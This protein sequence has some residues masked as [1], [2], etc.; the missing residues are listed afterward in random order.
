[1]SSYE[2]VAG[3][4]KSESNS[5]LVAYVAD[6][7][8]EKQNIWEQRRVVLEAL[9]NQMRFLLSVYNPT[10]NLPNTTKSKKLYYK[11]MLAHQANNV[12]MG[13]KLTPD[14][15]D[16]APLGIE[17]DKQLVNIT[18]ALTR[19]H[20]GLRYQGY[21]DKAVADSKKDLIWGNSFIEMVLKF[22]GDKI[23][24]VEYQHAP[25]A[26]IRNNYGQPDRI[27]AINYTPEEYAEEYS[28]EELLDV[29]EGGIVES[30]K[31]LL[32]SEVEKLSYIPAGQIQVVRYY[33]PARRIF[34][35]VHGGNGKIY[36]HLEGD[37]YPLIGREGEGFDPFL[38]SRFYEDPTADY[39]GYGVFDFLIDLANLDT[40]ITNAVTAD[41]V[42][43]AS[44]PTVIESDDPDKTRTQLRKWEKNRAEG[45]N[46]VMVEKNSGLGTKGKV[47]DLSRAVRTDIM[48]AFDGTITQKA[49][50]ASNIVFDSLTDFAPTAE[51]QKIQRLEADKLNLRVLMGNEQ[52]EIEFAR[53][54]LYFL[55][56]T[57]TPFH[58]YEIEVDDEFS[59]KYR[60]EDGFKP[61]RKVKIGDILKETDKLHLQVQPRL[62]GALDDMT[63]QEIAEMS[64]DI[65]LM[66]DGT[67]AQIIALDKYINKKN[68]GWGIQ[69]RDFATP[70]TPDAVAA[71]A[72][73]ATPETPAAAAALPSEPIQ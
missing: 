35:E 31:N 54:E 13:S 57:H 64:E 4:E 46:R 8:N 42:W 47:T 68:P 12:L 49:T 40:T 28:E 53:K 41:A 18:D 27:R 62:E 29:A 45:R 30:Q 63:F 70:A 59:E 73:V 38:E 21:Y 17:H 10:D 66:P 65:G 33:N 23:A 51:Q 48:D 3:A 58:N 2:L 50:R 19:A 56:N 15:I 39:F 67:Q 26:E 7:F 24:G 72:A 36:Q 44:A 60:G 6:R 1:M 16:Y 11:S 71:Q 9:K 20:K 55:N 69:R 61:M 43:S 25:F 22:D 34:A 14:F 52:R 37:N 32:D 5:D